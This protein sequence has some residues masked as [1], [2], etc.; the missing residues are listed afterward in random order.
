MRVRRVIGGSVIVG[1]LLALVA[2]LAPASCAAADATL[3]A[4]NE[5]RAA[6]EKWTKAFNAR[7]SSKVCALFAPD[8]IAN[9]QGQP[10]RNY[11]SL[12]A[13]LQ[14]SVGDPATSY[15]YDLD[16]QEIIVSGDLAVVRLIW[17]LTLR[18]EK[19]STETTIVEPGL[20]VF[21]RQ[22]DGAWKIE[23]FIAYPVTAP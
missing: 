21:R 19:K 16:L 20:D 6:L 18:R 14:R 22:S 8:L 4:R 7:D 13:Q 17:T 2:L 5:I 1:V 9:Y 15:H 23:R 10:Q 12:C 3:T 11:R